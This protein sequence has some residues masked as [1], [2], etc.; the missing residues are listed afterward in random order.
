MFISFRLILSISR[1]QSVILYWLHRWSR[2]Q[3]LHCG[4]SNCCYCQDVMDA[5]WIPEFQ[6]KVQSLCKLIH[7]ICTA[8]SPNSARCYS[9][10]VT[11]VGEWNWCFWLNGG[12]LPSPIHFVF[13]VSKVI[14]YVSAKHVNLLVSGN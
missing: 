14:Q 6:C 10:W 9:S 3:V 4:Y 7:S 2:L 1:Q 8:H 12:L 5:D 13:C 11:T